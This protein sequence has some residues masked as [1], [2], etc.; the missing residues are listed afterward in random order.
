MLTTDYADNTAFENV[1]REQTFR[2]VLS[3]DF[4]RSSYKVAVKAGYIYTYMAYDY[5][6]DVG[7]GIMAN[8][9]ESRSK[10]NTAYAQAEAEYYL[11]KE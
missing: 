9:T 5:K 11:G 7:N 10:V 1:Q 8:M 6:R 3:W 2:G 4:L